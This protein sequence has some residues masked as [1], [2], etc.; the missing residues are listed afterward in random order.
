[1][2]AA[3]LWP[4]A[5]AAVL[6]ITVVANVVLLLKAG[7]DGT[8]VEPDYYRKAVAWD[9]VMAQARHNARLAWHVGG[10]LERDGALAIDLVD[11]GGEP[12]AGALVRV[13]G[14][15]VAHA[16]G[17]AHAD[18]APAAQPGRYA[19]RLPAPRPGLHE[20]RVSVSRDGER[21]TA[22]LRGEPGGPLA[23]RP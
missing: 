17:P 14:F 6:G 10:R 20:V 23:P 19:G 9:S 3:A 13:E 8:A 7:A 12:L 2:K 1:M 5:L 11:A 22:A 4:L 18:L 15:A 16:G 21:F